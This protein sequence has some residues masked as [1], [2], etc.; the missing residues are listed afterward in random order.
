VIRAA[1]L[2]R[3]EFSASVGLSGDS[4]ITALWKKKEK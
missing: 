2:V 4:N 3:K 1:F